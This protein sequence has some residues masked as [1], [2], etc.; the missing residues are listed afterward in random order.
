M[1]NANN[2]KMKRVLIFALVIAMFISMAG[3]AFAAEG[4]SGAPTAIYKLDFSDPA[5]RGKNTAGSGIAD[6]NIVGQTGVAYKENDIKGGT[7]LNLT[8]EGHHAN[9]VEIPGEVLNNE[10]VTIAG[11]FKISSSLPNWS[12]MLEIG[13]R[14]NGT[15]EYSN[16]SIMPYGPNVY[17]A[18]HINTFINGQCI[19]GAHDYDNMMFEGADPNTIDNTPMANYVLPVFDA[20]VHYAYELTPEG[21]SIYQNGVL[22]VTKAGNFTAS[23]FYSEVAKITLG[24]T[25][26]DGTA[27]FTGGY[28]DIRVYDK[29][30]TGEQIKSEYNLTY[31]DFLTTSYDFENGMTES[32]RGY[33]ATAIN[34]AA[35]AYDEAKGSNVLV[36]DGA[37]AVPGDNL[38]HTSL[39]LPKDVVHG[40][41]QITMSMDVYIDS[42]CGNYARIFEFAPRGSQAF[43]LGAKWGDDTTMVLKFTANEGPG[44]QMLIMETP[45]DRWVNITVTLD[46]TRAAVY[47]DGELVAESDNFIYKNSIFWERKA[48]T[49]MTIG[50]VRFWGDRALVG[51]MDNIQ[52]YQTV[53]TAEEVVQMLNGG[54]DTTPENPNT[55][56]F[57]PVILCAAVLSAAAMAVLCLNR[58]KYI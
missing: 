6:A 42:S 41:N 33:N 39:E 2:K 43:M 13:N 22:Q 7:S 15:G 1:Y 47:F 46:G 18:L 37:Q 9:Y 36:L 23:Q 57:T 32:I 26:H 29:A 5:N 50:A 8:S 3:M 30:L 28:A 49:Y 20:W 24:A 25:F 16:I 14:L 10:S 4:D 40:H 34:T 45:F 56:D 58:K 51:K 21:F 38:T 52:I 54:E 31:K 44:N 48:D 11:W 53:L 19:L 17:N 35:T 27:D 55:G 12:R